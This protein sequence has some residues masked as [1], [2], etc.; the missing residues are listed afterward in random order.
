MS[1]ASEK[2]LYPNGYFFECNHV[3]QYRRRVIKCRMRL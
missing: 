2:N 1:S 3:V